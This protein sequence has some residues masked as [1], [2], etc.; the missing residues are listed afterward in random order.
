MKKLNP[1]NILI[2]VLIV[3]VIAVV[4]GVVIPLCIAMG[5][6]FWYVALHNYMLS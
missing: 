3:V 5:R 2:A 1:D 4:V 6:A